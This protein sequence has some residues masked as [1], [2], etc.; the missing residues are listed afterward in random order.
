MMQVVVLLAREVG[1]RIKRKRTPTQCSAR[2]N[3]AKKKKHKEKNKERK[4]TI[5]IGDMCTLT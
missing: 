5:M 1:Q 2:L 4:E 3:A